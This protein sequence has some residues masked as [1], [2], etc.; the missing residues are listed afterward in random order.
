[1][2]PFHKGPW[3]ILTGSEGALHEAKRGGCQPTA[4]AIDVHP[5]PRPLDQQQDKKKPGAI[6]HPGADSAAAFFRSTKVSARGEAFRLALLLPGS[7]RS[8]GAAGERAKSSRGARDSARDHQK[9]RPRSSGGERVRGWSPTK[10]P[11]GCPRKRQPHADRLARSTGSTSC[12]RGRR[13]R[14]TAAAPA[15][16]AAAAAAAVAGR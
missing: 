8:S 14:P 9:L 13:P 16:A 11:I 3:V 10:V 6:P 2:A 1:L 7:D 4:S 5:I 12:D 15:A